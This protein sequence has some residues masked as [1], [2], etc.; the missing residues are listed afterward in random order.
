VPTEICIYISPFIIPH[1]AGFVNQNFYADPIVLL[2][3]VCD[4][5]DPTFQFYTAAA[6]VR[7]MSVFPTEAAT[8]KLFVFTQIFLE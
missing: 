8:K 5:P 4:P 3:S 1:F 7:D 6:Q 2:T